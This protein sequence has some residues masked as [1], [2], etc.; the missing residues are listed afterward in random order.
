MNTPNRSIYLLLI[1]LLC[2]CCIAGCHLGKRELKSIKTYTSDEDIA[3]RSTSYFPEMDSCIGSLRHKYNIPAVTVAIVRNDSLVYINCYGEQDV[4]KH[5]PTRNSSLFRTASISKP[6]TVVAL[7]HLMQEGKLAMDDR[8]FGESSILRE[9]FGPLP[10][11]SAWNKITVRHL[12]EHKSGIQNRPNDPMFAYK[13]L[14]NKDIIKFVIRE[15][16]LETEPG[17][18]YYY[19]NLGYNILG[20]V[21]EKVSGMSYED[22]VKLNILE[23]CGITRMKL[24][25][26]TLEEKFEDEVIYVQPDEPDWV[27]TMDVRRMDAHGGWI[28]SATDLARFISHINRIEIVPDIVDKVWMKG[29]YLDF[30]KWTHTGSLPGTATVLARMND[31]FSYVFLA[32]CRSTC[33]DFWKDVSSCMETSINKREVWPNIDLF[34]KIKW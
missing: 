17:E 26:N 14:T 18:E 20:R 15:R 16:P 31:E 12:I 7:L 6:V 30:E 3:E 23:P 1:I 34:E 28:A 13:G 21:I 10:V 29:T 4:E 19:S 25:S 32:N 5:I 27:Y 2:I 24:A 33:E 8:V 9:D 11:N 22:Y